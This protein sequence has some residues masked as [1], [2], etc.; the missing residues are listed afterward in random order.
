MT[1]ITNSM[2]V[3]NYMNNMQRNLGNMSTLQNQLSSG[4]NIQRASDNPYVAVRAM[5]LNTEI[6]ANE[7]YNTNIIDTSNW[8]D[9]TDTALGQASNI[10]KRIKELMIKAGN[11][12]YGEDEVAAINDEIVEKVKEFGQV[13]NTSFDGNFI[14]GG[15]KSTSK[16]VTVDTNGTISYADKSGNPMK[17]YLNVAGDVVKEPITTNNILGKDD[18]IYL[19]K[20]GNIIR[21][22]DGDDITDFTE[23]VSSDSLYIDSDGKITTKADGNQS[24]VLKDNLYIDAKNN[25]T[26]EKITDNKLLDTTNTIYYITANGKVTTESQLGLVGN[27]KISTAT[28]I[29]VGPDGKVIAPIGNGYNVKGCTQI[30]WGDALYENLNGD[31]VINKQTINTKFD[32]TEPLY[33]D[34]QGNV[35]SSIQQVD[36]TLNS[37]LP[38][39]SQ[40]YVDQNGNITTNGSG[41]NP[42]ILN[43][44]LYLDVDGN[45]KGLKYQETMPNGGVLTNPNTNI[46]V[47]ENGQITSK[48]KDGDKDNIKI[49]ISDGLYLDKDGNITVSPTTSNILIKTDDP[50][51]VDED[52]MVSTIEADKLLESGTAL[53]EDKDGN[54]TINKP[55]VNADPI[56]RG[57]AL[58]SD[59]NGR[60]TTSETSNNRKLI[61]ET[62][63]VDP[64]NKLTLNK[65]EVN[66]PLTLDD[67]KNLRDELKDS[68]ITEGRKNE[69]N[70]ILRD[71][72][73]TQLLQI[74][75]S[76]NAEISDGVVV[77]YNKTAADILE[78]KDTKGNNIN[79]MNQLSDLIKCLKI[80]SGEDTTGT[81][82]LSD[83]TQIGTAADALAQI[84]GNLLTNVDSI[85]QN[86][87]KLRSNVG[88]MQ[89]RMDSA[90]TANEDQNYNMTSILSQTEDID[91]A[92]KTMEY[93]VMQTVYIA[94]L[95]TSSKIL[96]N[97][98]LDYI[99]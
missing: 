41:N 28:P 97:T 7:Q 67:L 77:D 39:N 54:I 62:I 78:F 25:I 57:E 40:L 60:V 73:A 19:D 53:Y 2:L 48:G 30:N 66:E 29:Y 96:T 10:M 31:V 15:T 51:Y 89:N 98:L 94:A 38:A 70:T 75:S 85:S 23:M 52:G 21:P 95:Q 46:Y 81:A 36:G 11:G 99:N 6:T 24:I 22:K 14:F 50:L 20:E 18:K 59:I 56:N 16:P 55:S 5:Q 61:D 87:L 44:K 90:Q 83:G 33:L 72:Y 86:I 17:I 71:D 88:A 80:A 68:N 79:V 69:I 47:D 45:L 42:I 49:I 63:F 8:L 12:A 43:E 1:R 37:P 27:T 4:K 92:E 64:S 82:A 34:G 93:S 74:D 76:L 35:T 32:I 58:Y 3:L 84:N 65:T 26:T 9:T 91:F 13:L